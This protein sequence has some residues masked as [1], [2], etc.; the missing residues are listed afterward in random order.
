MRNIDSEYQACQKRDSEFGMTHLFM[1]GVVTLL[2]LFQ[3]HL[4]MAQETSEDWIPIA[5]QEGVSISYRVSKCSDVSYLFLMVAN[6]RQNTVDADWKIVITDGAGH[7]T[8]LEG[9]AKEM[10]ISELRIG[11]CETPA[12]TPLSIYLDQDRTIV[13]VAATISVVNK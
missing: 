13:S 11:S 2:M 3:S 1:G 4:I 8:E 10:P 9:F 12:P 6:E 7:Q 5:S